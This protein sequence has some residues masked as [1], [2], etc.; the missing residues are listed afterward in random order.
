M[1]SNLHFIAIKKK[2]KED[3]TQPG[4]LSLILMDHKT[5]LLGDL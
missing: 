3:L 4:E 2:S 1:F 5:L